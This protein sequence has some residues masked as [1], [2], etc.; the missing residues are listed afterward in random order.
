[1]TN[2]DLLYIGLE[3]LLG[4]AC[5]VVAIIASKFL[6]TKFRL[7]YLAAG[8]AT[9]IFVVATG[10]EIAFIPAYIIC[11]LMVLGFF[12]EKKGL[13]IAL[14]SLLMA[15]MLAEC[16][17][18]T[19]YTGYRAPD[20]LAEFDDAF[21]KMKQYYVLT[22]H[23]D[24]DFDE[25]YEKY[26]PQFEDV[27][28]RHD[29]IDNYI[30]WMS[31]CNEFKDGHVAYMEELSDSDSLLVAEKLYGYDY[32]FS[33]MRKSD[34]R[35]VAVNVEAGSEAEVAGI[36]NGTIIKTWNGEAVENMI[37]GFDA[38]LYVNIPVKESEDFLRVVFA[39]GQSGDSVVVGFVN[40]DSQETAEESD[41]TEATI[42]KIS[43]YKDRLDDTLAKLLDGTFETN[44]TVRTISADTAFMRID[45]MAYDSNSYGGNDYT[46]MY[47]DLR[48]KLQEQKDVGVSNL[49]ID[50]RANTGGDPNFDKTVFRLLFPEGEYNLLYSSV[51]DYDT[52]HYMIDASTGGYAVGDPNYFYGEGF[53][54]DGKIIVLVS[55]TTVSAGD[56][57]TEAISH[58]DNV[59]IMGI[60][61][62]NCSCQAVRGVDMTNGSLSFSAVPNLNA[63]GSVYI[64]TD[65]SREATI[66]LDVQ[67]AVD[68]T[69]IDEV[70]NK[71][72]D[73]IVNMA[74]ELI[75]Q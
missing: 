56:L 57:F 64:D 35:I 15:V 19:S 55:A 36:K 75:E 60:T 49:I 42:N 14:S 71:G 29:K 37:A 33:L 20:Y 23:K 9:V 22:E 7:V 50:L 74:L 44:L 63:D 54:G 4:A 26:R 58:L 31:F 12:I 18:C 47:E 46:K 40:A 32:G 65:A 73:Y 53:W 21:A 8:L 1:M 69:F 3:L 38:P 13:R 11:G 25:L 72:E 41:V 62:S 28:E 34:G 51:W 70:F 30:T 16:I 45:G 17:I 6:N 68:D 24:I 5:L 39:S 48:V 10:V 61:P 2:G 43:I 27:N 59:T 67:V 52:E 66:S